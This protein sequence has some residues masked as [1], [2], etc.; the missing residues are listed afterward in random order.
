MYAYYADVVDIVGL[1]AHDNTGLTTGGA[2]NCYYAT[3]CSVKRSELFDN[4]SGYGG[5]IAS[6]GGSLVV[7]DS[8]IYSNYGVRVL[9]NPTTHP[10]YPFF[11]SYNDIN[12]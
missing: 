2:V 3:F 7:A 8:N 11:F 4:W 9:K 5:A 10:P 6:T 12:T 1:T